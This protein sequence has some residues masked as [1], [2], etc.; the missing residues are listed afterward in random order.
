MTAKESLKERWSQLRAEEPKLRIKDAAEK[1]GVKEVELVSTDK[2]NIRLNDDWK[3]LFEAVESLGYVMALTRNNSVVHERKGEYHN[4]TFNNHVGLVLDPN[5]DLRIFPGKFGFAYAVTVHTPA[6]KSLNSIQFFDKHGVAAH[7]IY[8]MNDEHID[9]YHALVTNFRHNDQDS[10]PVVDT[11]EP[12]TP[13][14]SIPDFD[15]EALLADW[16]ELKDTHDFFPLLKKHKAERTHA[17]EIAEG[18][19]TQRVDNM[20]ATNMLHKASEQE[21][22][23]MVFVSSGSV[24]QIHTG[25]VTRI[26]KRGHWINVMDPEFNLHLKESDIAKSWI[27]EKPTE[28]GIVT[29]LE[30]FDKE[31]NN[32]AT[33]FGERKPG[34]PE[35]QS[36]KSLIQELRK[37]GV[38]A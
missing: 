9:H 27:V 31:N 12:A 28:D 5:I 32:I 16:A 22:P 19:F 7:K 37:E 18:K 4:I 8:L 35:L 3:G 2:N 21:V 20:T 25:K 14:E 23:I 36:W 24:I 30:I 29:S 6:G 11:S 15:P 26:I 13:Y 33:F 38:T 17:L 1:L 10:Y 34:K